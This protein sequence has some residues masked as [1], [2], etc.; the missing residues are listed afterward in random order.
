MPIEIDSRQWFVD[1]GAQGQQVPTE[2]QIIINNMESLQ[3]PSILNSGEVGDAVS[4][5][6]GIGRNPAPEGGT[7]SYAGAYTATKA[8]GD[9]SSVRSLPT[10]GVFDPGPGSRPSPPPTSGSGPNRSLHNRLSRQRASQQNT[11]QLPV[12]QEDYSEVIK[13]N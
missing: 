4:A 13:E 7:I 12:D 6:N 9:G 2:G 11:Y 1:N 3:R 8:A 10:L 5:Q